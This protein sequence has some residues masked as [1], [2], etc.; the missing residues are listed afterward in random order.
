[1]SS[2][3]SRLLPV[4]FQA[5]DGIRDRN[6]T[7]VQT[8]ALPISAKWV[9]GVSIVVSAPFVIGFLHDYHVLSGSLVA[10]AVSAVVCCLMSFRSN[11][12]FDFALLKERTGNFDSEERVEKAQE[13]AK[14][15]DD[16]A[17]AN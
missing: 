16:T 1:L 12:D 4:F 9:A 8:C 17:P 2:C 15:G 14:S 11:K 5:E 3:A 7:G 6:V 13:T 10:Y